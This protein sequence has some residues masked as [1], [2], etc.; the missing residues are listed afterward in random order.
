VSRQKETSGAATALTAA[1]FA[2]Y[3]S[4][5]EEETFFGSVEKHCQGNI[6]PDSAKEK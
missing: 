2:C 3:V 1:V 6:E 4:G 5:E